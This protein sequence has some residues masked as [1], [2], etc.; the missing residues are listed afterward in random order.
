MSAHTKDEDEDTFLRKKKLY[1]RL[2]LEQVIVKA[3][4]KDPDKTTFNQ[5]SELEARAKC[6][7]VHQRRP[8]SNK[9]CHELN[10]AVK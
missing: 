7:E 8:K 1:D 2:S 5:M 10:Y 6:F 9:T 3:C 4:G